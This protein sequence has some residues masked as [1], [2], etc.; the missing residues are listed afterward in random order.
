MW[1]EMMRFEWRY[2]LRQPGIYLAALIFFCV[3]FFA[4]QFGM[5]QGGGALKNGPF[6]TAQVMVFFSLFAIFLVVYCVA[7]SA[8]RERDSG[9]EELLY[10]QPIALRPY[11]LGRFIGA[12]SV[13]LALFLMVP[14]GLFLG[15]LMPWVD[16]SRFGAFDWRFYVLPWVYFSLPTLLLFASF[17]YLLAL[18]FRSMAAVYLA[19]V[20]VFVLYEVGS[21]WFVSPA[22]RHWAALLDPFGWHTFSAMTSYWSVTEKNHQALTLTPVLL[23]NRLLVLGLSGVLLALLLLFPQGARLSGAAGRRMKKQAKEALSSSVGLI[24]AQPGLRLVRAAALAN[25]PHRQV[26]LRCVRFEFV[27]MV[28]R[29]SFYLLAGC[30]LLLFLSGG[31]PQSF[32]GSPLWPTTHSMVALIRA[33]LS[34]IGLL[35]IAYYSAD[36][37]WR[38][39]DCGIADVLHSLPVGNRQW[40]LAKLSALALLLL[41]LLALCAAIAIV[42]QMAQGWSQIDASQYLIGLLYFTL[43]P[44]LMWVVLAL[45]LQIISPNKYTGLLLFALFV[46][47]EFAL[48]RLGFSQTLFQFAASPALSYS[49]MAGYGDS[50]T[51]HHWYMLYWGALSLVLLLLGS[52]LWRRGQDEGLRQRFRGLVARL[53]R[54][55][56]VAV[57]LSAI[58][59]VLSAGVIVY[60]TKVLN[61]DASPQTLAAYH[62]DYEQRFRSWLLAP[63]PQLV[64]LDAAVD[65]Y[66][67]QRKVEIHADLLVRNNSDEPIQG[68]LVSMPGYNSLLTDTPAYR[69]LT[70]QLDIDGG[71]LGDES[72]ALNTHWFEFEQPLAAGESRSGS[73]Q[74][75][76]QRGGFSDQAQDLQLVENGSF[77][78]NIEAF[79]RFGYQA[80]YELSDPQ[81]RRRF[82]LPERQAMAALEDSRYYQQSTLGPDSSYLDFS[83][84]VSTSAD[85]MAFTPGYLQRSWET[86]GRRYF[87]YEMDA[88]IGNYFAFLSGRYA[89]ARR[90]HGEVALA[91]Y[92]HPQHGMNVERMLQ[93][94]ADALDYYATAF[95]PYQHHQMRIVEFPGEK[96]VAQDFPNMI[97]FAEPMGFLHD[98]R[99]AQQI[100]QVYY[101]TAHEM[102]H[103][104]W[105]AQIDGAA[106]QGNTVLSETLAQ[107][108]AYQLVRRRYGD[109]RLRRMLRYDLDYYLLGRSR[110]RVAEQPLLRVGDQPYLHY[111]KGALVMM[112]AADLLGEARLNQGLAE[113]L[114][115]YRFSAAPYPTTQDLL[116]FVYR[117]ATAG[118]QAL[119]AGWFEAIEL[120]D[121]KLLGVES[122]ALAQGGFEITLDIEAHRYRAN[123][124]GQEEEIDLDEMIPLALVDHD[125]DDPAAEAALAD[126]SSQ[127]KRV[128]I[129]RGENRIRLQLDHLPRFI[130]L[131]PLITRI[132]RNLDDQ[133]VAL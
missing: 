20:A 76:L 99:D 7:R 68:F 47:C 53:N 120:Y 126:L 109:V 61:H 89:V 16:A 101:I 127:L 65:F 97:A 125:P 122:Q 35:V 39:Q 131:D 95:G 128:R 118:E 2:Y 18:R 45:F 37:V 105:G 106:V 10:C 90:Q 82:K 71:S 9:M 54:P 91:V 40:Y 107:Y 51:S 112:A 22:T 96:S 12:Y 28:H 8:L 113:F 132:D 56:R 55:Q 29:Y 11:H 103:Q 48:G 108:S 104:W 17:F 4:V 74:V 88:P 38:E 59:F 64:Q 19:V 77:I 129:Q 6:M 87:R 25:W 41:C 63:V 93:A 36:V 100:D 46:L 26:F 52:A 79:P 70:Y 33:P 23:H 116:R 5:S 3:T 98:L 67:A 121:L 50:L 15:S 27:Q 13:V 80:D 124:Q 75:V 85:Q 94:L 1:L 31:A 69:P 133:K 78:Q 34:I 86:Q 123:G 72:F 30:L 73:F 92:H 119:L 58:V 111:N 110:E 81:Q 117:Q 66:P 83:A 102:A 42:F 14:L 114:A 62:A 57:V 84:T 32:Y 49:D 115:A 43:L 60:N 130:V 44:W 21:D 24:R